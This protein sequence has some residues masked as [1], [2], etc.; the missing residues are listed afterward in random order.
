MYE[1]ASTLRALGQVG[2]MPVSEQGNQQAL[3]V[4]TLG[5]VGLTVLASAL[6]LIKVN[7]R[8]VLLIES[9]IVFAFAMMW[10][11]NFV[12]SALRQCTPTNLQLVPRLPSL[13]KLAAAA[14]WLAGS[15]ALALMMALQFGN[16]IP[17]WMVMAL[18]MSMLAWLVRLPRF[19]ILP[20]ALSLA[21]L[22]PQIRHIDF[23]AP[24]AGILVV[25]ALATLA[26]AVFTLALL[27]DL[28][29]ERGYRVQKRIHVERT[30]KPSSLFQKL[31]PGL[32]STLTSS[33]PLYLWML[34]RALAAESQPTKLIVFVFG[35]KAHW[36]NLLWGLFLTFWLT[37]PLWLSLLI[38]DSE[39]AHG[40]VNALM[41]P[42]GAILFVHIAIQP[43]LFLPTRREQGLLLLSPRAPQGTELNRQVAQILL[44]LFPVHSL[45][46]L[47]IF[48]IPM[49]LLGRHSE[50][51]SLLALATAL[52]GGLFGLGVQLKS[53]ARMSSRP[54]FDIG[55]ALKQTFLALISIAPLALT[56]ALFGS[57][58]YLELLAV[59]LLFALA[60]VVRRW[61]RMIDGPAVVPAG[62]LA[63]D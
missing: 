29:G 56:G 32:L 25:A 35:P 46:L 12:G 4:Y 30:A 59:Y 62:R 39:K 24:D 27:F 22:A 31:A 53:Y 20:F 16:L 47:C 14:L 33:R 49:G 58:A 26:F 21:L 10:W 60:F 13:V 41:I 50:V 1:F 61:R 18:A 48:A 63:D 9:I 3:W 17:W 2:R 38:W 57:T 23:T 7:L 42:L 19:V 34:K 40:F 11:V 6:L 45:A 51:F 5:L 15:L 43:M 52:V 28:K 54:E 36:S 8:L 37:F 55:E 44:R